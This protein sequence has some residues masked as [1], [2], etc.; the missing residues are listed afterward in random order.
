MATS[1]NVEQK[2]TVEDFKIDD[3]LVN[4][5]ALESTYANNIQTIAVQ[6]NDIFVFNLHSCLRYKFL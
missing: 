2:I 1:S 6:L 4:P 5:K 3:Y